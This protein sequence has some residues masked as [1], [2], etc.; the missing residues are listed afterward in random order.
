MCGLHG[1]LC[2]IA[3][4]VICRWCSENVVLTCYTNVNAST[5]SLLTLLTQSNPLT[6]VEGNVLV[7]E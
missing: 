3:V 7:F 1:L 5:I 4:A 2:G 6:R